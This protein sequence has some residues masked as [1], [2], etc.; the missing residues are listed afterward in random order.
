MTFHS[1][2]VFSRL[3]AATLTVA[4]IGFYAGIVDAYPAHH[5]YSSGVARATVYCPAGCRPDQDVN[6]TWYALNVPLPPEPRLFA[7]SFAKTC[8]P[9]DVLRI[10]AP[11][12]LLATGE[13]SSSVK[14]CPVGSLP[15]AHP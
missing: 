14:S 7:A 5:L 13:R 15:A 2:P 11:K 1:A 10:D 8:S 3:A 6:S 12:L 9:G 4:P